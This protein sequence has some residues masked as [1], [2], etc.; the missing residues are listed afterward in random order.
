MTFFQLSEGYRYNSDTLY[1][2]DF[3]SRSLRGNARGR[4]LDVGCGCGVLGLLLAR[5]YSNLKLTSL[6]VQPINC[7]ITAFNAKFNG[8]KSETI[9]EDF[10]KYSNLISQ[11]SEASLCDERRKHPRGPSKTTRPATRT[12]F[13]DS[14]FKFEYVISN[15]PFYDFGTPSPEP[16]VEISRSA[17]HLPLR[18]LVG[19]AASVLEPKGKFYFCY[20]ARFLGEI[21]AVLNEFKFKLTALRFVYPKEG[22]DAKIAM[23]EAR[24]NSKTPTKV[25]PPLVARIGGEYSEET[26]AIFAKAATESRDYNSNLNG[27][28]SAE[29]TLAQAEPITQSAGFRDGESRAQGETS[30][31]HEIKEKSNLNDNS[32]L[33]YP[34][35]F[36]P[37]KCELCGGKC[38]TGESGYIWLTPDEISA[39]AAA[40]NTTAS[41]FRALYTRKVGV[42]VSLKEKPHAQGFACVFFEDGK[43]S[44][45]EARPAQCR[46]FPFWDYYANRVEELEKECIGVTRL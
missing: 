4:V 21:L 26:R 45:Y 14:D 3:I 19:G 6:D 29:F 39:L 30:P 10:T 31:R 17:S 42:R 18:A 33:N 11:G 43:C 25:H 40:T 9:N 12:K 36:D 37:T 35:K 2:Y 34:F 38:C 13:S 32:N 27:E 1:L 7:E 24:L 44:V 46:S 15:P 8:V 22:A 5:D 23:F 16:H 41:E 20:D 28:K